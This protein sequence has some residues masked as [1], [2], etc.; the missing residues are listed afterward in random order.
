MV[1]KQ[2]MTRVW[3]PSH[4]SVTIAHPDQADHLSSTGGGQDTLAQV[5]DMCFG[6]GA[7]DTDTAAVQSISWE[8]SRHGHAGGDQ[9]G[10]QDE[11][12]VGAHSRDQAGAVNNVFPIF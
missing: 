12:K 8:E 10:A 6:I 5:L 9:A 4:S 7:G 2:E 11:D 3:P 1:Q